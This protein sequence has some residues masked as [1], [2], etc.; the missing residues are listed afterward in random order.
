LHDANG[1]LIEQDLY[2]ANGEPVE[3]DTIDKLRNYFRD[4]DGSVDKS[5]VFFALAGAALVGYAGKKLYDHFNPEEEQN[6][7]EQ[8]KQQYYD[9]DGRPIRQLH[10]ANGEL[11]EQDLYDANGEPVEE[12]T[13]DKL[14]N[15]FRDE[16]GSVDKSRVLFALAGTV[17][18]GYLGKRIYRHFNPEE[19]QSSYDQ[20]KQQYY[21]ANGRPIRQLH[22]ANGD[23]IEQ[24]LYDSNGEPVEEDTLDKLRNY[25]RDEDGSVDKSRVFLALA[26]AAL[27]GYAGKKIFD[28]FNP[29]EEKSKYDDEKQQYYDANGRPIRQLHDANGDLIEQDLYDSNGEPVEED[30][31]DKLR[32]YFRDEDGSVDKSRVFFALAGAALVGYAGK[33]LYDHFNPEEEQNKYEQEKQQYY[34]ADGRP[35]RQLHDA[36]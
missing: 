24:D 33:K 20:E 7:Y 35:I 34:D 5:R 36:N 17:L 19:M 6:K 3:E 25:F 12:D 9:A 28:H 31:L 4:E 8:E 11:I 14:R 16:D 32:N 26:G 29:E 27:V 22:D 23:L 18:V 10:D 2:D 21:D 13:I 30:T 1:E 15:Y